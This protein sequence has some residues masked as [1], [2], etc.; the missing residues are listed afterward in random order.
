MHSFLF[1]A[2][3]VLAC[4]PAPVAGQSRHEITV[5]GTRF[6]LN[7][8]PFPYTG[9]S[10][11]NA[12]YNAEFNR[13]ADDRRRWLEKFRR[14]GINVVRIWAQWDTRRGFVDACAECSLY[15]PD[16]RLRSENVERVKQ[17][18]AAADQLGMVIE[19][20]LFARESASRLE[21]EP[22]RRAITALVREL[23][24]HRNLVV[25]I[26]NENSDRAL[27]HLKSVK[28]ADG[29][30][31]V[32]NS[33]GVAGVLGDRAQNEALDFLSPHTTRHGTGPHWEV[34]PREIALLLK[35]YHKPVVDDEPARTG[36]S[37]YGGPRGPTFPFDHILQIYQVWQLG[38]YIVYHHDMFQT[39]AGSAAVPPHGIPDPE[40]SPYHRQVLE[41]IALRDRYMPPAQ[42]PA[43]ERR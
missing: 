38:G 19:L 23:L 36:T 9:I 21:P 15:Y 2:V 4:A 24:P 27:E 43:A 11:F 35:L 30:R 40:F 12:I 28:E 29:E 39:G 42:P 3:I 14:Y 20:T 22:A 17:I 8:A 5:S 34:A 6:L 1:L 18:A 41:F 33:P 7:G 10:F 16:G 32:T 25:Q 37:S 13:S 26:W 31:L